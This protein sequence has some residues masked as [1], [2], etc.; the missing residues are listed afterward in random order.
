MRILPKALRLY[1]VF[2]LWLV[3]I[4][5]SHL[6]MFFSIKIVLPLLLEGSFSSLREFPFTC[7]HINAQTNTR[8]LSMWL[9]PSLESA[10]Q[11]LAALD[12]LNSDLCLPTQSDTW[13]LFRFLLLA[14]QPRNSLQAVSGGPSFISLPSGVTVHTPCCPMSEICS[15]IDFVCFANCI[16]LGCCHCCWLNPIPIYSIGAGSRSP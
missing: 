6:C 1:K 13:V 11:I 12:S 2:I 9:P 15:F 3:E 5:S 16:I 8:I 10:S 7:A 14:L 4:L